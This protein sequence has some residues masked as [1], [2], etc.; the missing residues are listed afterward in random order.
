MLRGKR[1]PQFRGL[2]ISG[3]LLL[4]LAFGTGANAQEP[5]QAKRPF[6][7]IGHNPN[8]LKNA[9]AFLL[10]G[11]NALEPDVQARQSGGCVGGPQELM[12]AHDG[13]CFPFASGTLLKEYL[14]LDFGHTE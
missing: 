5:F 3:L 14:K 12:I 4:T 11:S 9:Q 8:T 2:R 7:A 6:W 10:A 1:C 13:V